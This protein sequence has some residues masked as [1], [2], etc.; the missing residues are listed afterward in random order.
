M[1]ETIKSKIQS[2]NAIY[3]KYIQN[4]RFESDFFF[5]ENLL[6]EINEFISSTKALYYE[7]LA[8]K[9]NSSL[10]QEKTYWSI[11]KTIYSNKKI[12][13]ILPLL[14]DNKF[15][16]DMKTKAY[17]CNDFFAEQCTPMKNNTVLSI[18]QIFLTQSRT[19]FSKSSEL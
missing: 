12:S 2:K 13:L 14:V 3:K 16:T 9:L 18:N 4:G 1:K 7:N 15:V 17:I 5:F 11:P 10:L 19:K 8:K 6:T